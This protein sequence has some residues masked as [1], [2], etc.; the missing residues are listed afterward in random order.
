MNAFHLQPAADGPRID[1]REL[2]AS[3]GIRHKSAA[4]L[5]TRYAD[6]FRRF[7]ELPCTTIEFAKAARPGLRAERSFMLNEDQC[8]YLLALSR[9]TD[10]IADL[11]ADLVAAFATARRG[12]FTQRL[13]TM[14]RLIALEAKDK[15]SSVKARIGAQLMNERKCAL[16]SLRPERNAL[17]REL[18]PQLALMH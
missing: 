17:E 7:G 16:Q 11:K 14:E 1:T 15:E 13:S 2:S 9:N 3:L 8:Y 12:G 4:A 6:K 18:Q 10:R 5:V